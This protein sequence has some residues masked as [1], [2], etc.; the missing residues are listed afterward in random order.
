M[1]VI[2][3]TM[4]LNGI[5]LLRLGPSIKVQRVVPGAHGEMEDPA[6]CTEMGKIRLLLRIQL[7]N[8]K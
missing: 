8:A 1:V 5:E 2:M 4:K 6:F 7:L 3:F